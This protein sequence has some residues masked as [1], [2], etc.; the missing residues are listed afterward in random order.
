[1]AHIVPTSIKHQKI[2]NDLSQVYG[3]TSAYVKQ[4]CSKISRDDCDMFGG[5]PITKGNF[6]KTIIF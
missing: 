3:C 4:K 5:V 2:K 6:V 1:M